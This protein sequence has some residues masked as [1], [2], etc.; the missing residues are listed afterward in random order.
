MQQVAHEVICAVR[1]YLAKRLV[2]GQPPT[3]RE[4]HESEDGS[5]SEQ[6]LHDIVLSFSAERVYRTDSPQGMVSVTHIYNLYA[7]EYCNIAIPHQ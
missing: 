7:D 2:S 6:P 1:E 5:E 3:R 4:A